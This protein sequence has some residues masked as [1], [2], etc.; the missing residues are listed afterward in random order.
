MSAN[1]CL[2][3]IRAPLKLWVFVSSVIFGLCMQQILCCDHQQQG[4]TLFFTTVS[5]R[6]RPKRTCSGVVC[7]GGFHINRFLH[8]ILLLRRPIT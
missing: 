3:V 6:L 4:T 7:F 2:A 1:F 5:M 8:P